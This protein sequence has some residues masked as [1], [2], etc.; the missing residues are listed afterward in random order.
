MN[1]DDSYIYVFFKES[2]Q[3]EVM[4]SQE[5]LLQRLR[6]PGWKARLS[7][8]SASKIDFGV[9]IDESSGTVGDELT[10][11]IFSFAHFATNGY[12]C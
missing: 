8:I 9:I 2:L 3:L 5:W 1:S 6:F 12:C 11:G 10:P 4:L 7:V